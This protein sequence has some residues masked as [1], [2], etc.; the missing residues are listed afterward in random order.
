M[1]S[2]NHVGLFGQISGSWHDPLFTQR[3]REKQ[4]KAR[5]KADLALYCDGSPMGTH[6]P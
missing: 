6:Q 2:S 5:A 1:N 3:Q 4:P